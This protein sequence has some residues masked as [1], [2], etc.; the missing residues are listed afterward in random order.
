MQALFLI[1]H[2]QKSQN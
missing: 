1:E 2:K